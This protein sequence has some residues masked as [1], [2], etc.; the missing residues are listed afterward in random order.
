MLIDKWKLEADTL[1][2][3]IKRYQPIGSM[4]IAKENIY[5]LRKCISEA[6]LLLKN[7]VQ[8]VVEVSLKGKQSNVRKAD[9]ARRAKRR[10]E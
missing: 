3:S 8:N 5:R 4:S 2:Y 1:D 10:T 6:E 7:G 9:V